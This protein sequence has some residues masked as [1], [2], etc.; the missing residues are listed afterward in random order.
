MTTS[1]QIGRAMIRVARDGYPKPVLESEDI[2]RSLADPGSMQ[3]R[4]AIASG[5]CA[6]PG[7]PIIRPS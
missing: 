6:A 1:E 2:N 5:C 4:N 7:G 3:L